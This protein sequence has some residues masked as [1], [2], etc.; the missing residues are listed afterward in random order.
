VGEASPGLRQT[1]QFEKSCSLD[2]GER[3]KRP[4]EGEIHS[5]GQFEPRFADVRKY[6]EPGIP[7]RSP[8]ENR[9]LDI[10]YLRTRD[11]RAYM[12]AVLGLFDLKVIGFAL[13][14]NMT[15]E[16][17]TVHAL[18]VSCMNRRPKPV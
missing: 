8:G 13:S 7:R 1:G 16:H 15:A 14:G 11:G 4:A 5:G 18:A 2:A 12:T 6:A 9:L 10:T 3:L 17:T